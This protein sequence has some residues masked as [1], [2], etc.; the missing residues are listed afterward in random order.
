MGRPVSFGKATGRFFGNYLCVLTIFI[1]YFM[2]FFND[3]QQCLHD[4][5]AGTYVVN[6]QPLLLEDDIIEHLID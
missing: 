6:D 3:K 1:G 2:F 4:Y 5:L